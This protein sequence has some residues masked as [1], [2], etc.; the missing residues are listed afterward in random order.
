MSRVIILTGARGVGKTTVCRQA[1]TLAKE[2]GYA[3]GGILTLAHNTAANG[4]SRDARDVL[5]VST[6]RRHRLTQSSNGDEAVIQGRFRFDP[7]VLDW[8]NTVLSQAVPCDLL[9]VD[10]VGPLEMERSE[11]WVSAFDV[12]QGGAY[13]LA[14][15]VVRPELIAQAQERLA[16]RVLGILTVTRE[17]R[18]GL[19][20]KLVEMVK[21]E[22]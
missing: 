1:V 14:V 11:G 21:R 3:C 16:G 6:G 7:Q 8:G 18:D 19:P 22:G 20:A 17:N 5:D 10:E 4:R 13:A 9:V 12:L 15:P 2:R